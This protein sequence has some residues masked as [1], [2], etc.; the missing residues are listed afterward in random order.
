MIHIPYIYIY[1]VVLMAA[2]AIKE[3]HISNAWTSMVLV[4]RANRMIQDC[5]RALPMDD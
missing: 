2:I 5:I 3:A 4:S 1:T